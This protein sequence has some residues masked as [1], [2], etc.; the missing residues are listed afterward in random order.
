MIA[1]EF[2]LDLNPNDQPRF[3]LQN[4]FSSL[5]ELNKIFKEY[6]RSLDIY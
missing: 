4:S 5:A 6:L 2:A 1:I 3:Q